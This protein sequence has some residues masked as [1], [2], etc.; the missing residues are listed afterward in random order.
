MV[1]L[2]VGVVHEHG[3]NCKNDV[4]KATVGNSLNSEVNLGV[5][6]REEGQAKKKR[7]KPR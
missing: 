5:F 3:R 4:Q 6:A 1:D 7:E 2:A